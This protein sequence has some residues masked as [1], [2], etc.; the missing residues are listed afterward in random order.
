MD[1]LQTIT[2]IALGSGGL[3][4]GLMIAV[5]WQHGEIQRLRARQ[6]RLLDELLNADKITPQAAK[7]VRSDSNGA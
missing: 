7:N 1:E 5:R 4:V 2:S 6:E 3:T